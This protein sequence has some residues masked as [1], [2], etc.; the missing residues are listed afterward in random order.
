MACIAR[1]T[2]WRRTGPTATR[3]APGT[4]SSFITTIEPDP[5]IEPPPPGKVPC[6]WATSSWPSGRSR[7]C[8]PNHGDDAPPGMNAFSSLAA[9]NA[10]AVHRRVDEIA[11]GRLDHLDLVV[12]RALDV[13][14][15]REDA[16]PG[17]PAG[18]E[19][20]ERGTTVHDDP[21]DVRHGLDVVDHRGLVVDA[22]G[23]RDDLGRHLDAREPALALEALEQRGFLAADVG[24]GAG[25]HD[26]LD[27][28][29]RPE[30]VAPDRAVRVGLVQRR[31]HAFE[32]QRELTAAR[33]GISGRTGWRR[34]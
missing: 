5:S 7:C 29:P 8:G 33:T 4:W 21:R 14:G 10:S 13:T 20:G 15:Q 23:G 31:L 27:R 11:E 9:L 17:R 1:T 28:E 16:R 12:A 3:R 25:M 34:R 26:G 30:D 18:T 24:A 2:P 6:A 32:A 22:D 19:G